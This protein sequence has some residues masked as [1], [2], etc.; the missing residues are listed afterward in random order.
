MLRLM[1]EKSLGSVQAETAGRGG[2]SRRWLVDPWRGN[3]DRIPVGRHESAAVSLV[4]ERHSKGMALELLHHQR[5]RLG[6]QRFG[7]ERVA[8][9]LSFERAGRALHADQRR[10][11][12]Q[13]QNE[14]EMSQCQSPR[15]C[16]ALYKASIQI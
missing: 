8:A 12:A 7:V 1:P 5:V 9:V 4:G 15:A 14:T 6:Q 2:P 16:P 3:R 10:R 13:H 11:A